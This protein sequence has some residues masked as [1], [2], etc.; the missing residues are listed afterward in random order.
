MPLGGNPVAVAGHDS[1]VWAGTTPA[2]EGRGGTL[3]MLGDRPPS[4]LDP[5]FQLHYN[6]PQ[7]S[8]L[9]HDGLVTLTQT[10]GPRGLQLVPDLAVALPSPTDA[11]TSFTFQLRPG[12]RYST[13][14]P[15]RAGD[16]R[17]AFE[18]LFR[19]SSPGAS[20]YGALVGADRCQAQPDDCRLDGGV[21]TN[22]AAGTVTFR[23]STPDPEF[24]FRLAAM[25]YAVPVPPGTRWRDHGM[26]PIPGTGPYRVV[27]VGADKLRL[28]RNPHFEEWS[29]AAQPEGNPDAIV[30]RYDLDPQ[31]QID[32][33]RSGRADWMD[34][35][36]HRS[37]RDVRN[38]D[39]A[40]LHVNDTP[41][42][43]FLV[44]RTQQPPFDDVRVRRALNLAIDRGRAVRG[45]GGPEQ[46]TPT[47]QVLPRTDTARVPYCPYTRGPDRWGTWRAPDLRRARRLVAQAP[48]RGST[49]T[50]LGISDEPP[51]EATARAAARALRRL[52]YRAEL[53]IT[54]RGELEELPLSVRE[55]FDVGPFVW[56]ADFPSPSTFFETM[57]VCDA[58]LMHGRICM[59]ALDRRIAAAVASEAHDRGATDRLWTAVDRIATDRA[60][61]VPLVNP[62]SVELTSARLSGYQYNPQWGFLP[63]LA[64]VVR[65]PPALRGRPAGAE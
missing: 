32:A 65:T 51:S 31:E 55:S 5:G 40:R 43:D 41:G 62:R 24:L 53:T 37:W 8:G 15:V 60:L 23:L 29:Y 9:V 64:S 42:T 36:P 4:T 49:V 2:G 3:T 56:F 61:T 39:A 63:A 33:V 46:A 14:V 50:V 26:Q 13:G 28:E 18:R 38:H 54:T 11:A 27:H 52:G 47:C 6:P 25:S 16:F 10:S 58:P 17:R 34:G 57:L 20:Y 44:L 48:T 21:V 22:D 7:L 19:G 30:W 59:P 1:T 35:I 12:I 45:Y